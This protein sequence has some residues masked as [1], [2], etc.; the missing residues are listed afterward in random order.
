MGKSHV[1]LSLFA[2]ISS[3]EKFS[4]NRVPD[5]LTINDPI[6]GNLGNYLYGGAVDQR[7]VLRG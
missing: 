2:K 4:R 3:A 5:N 7:L 1:R 6:S